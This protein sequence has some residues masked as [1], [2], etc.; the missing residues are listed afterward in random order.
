MLPNIARETISG[1]GDEN[2]IAEYHGLN[3]HLIVPSIPFFQDYPQQAWMSG[4]DWEQQG[5][6][7]ADGYDYNDYYQ[8]PNTH[9]VQS[10]YNG[11]PQ[12]YYGYN[13]EDMV[14]EC[15]I[16]PGGQ[17]PEYHPSR[18]AS[19][20]HEG[21]GQE[22]HDRQSTDELLANHLTQTEAPTSHTN[23]SSSDSRKLEHKSQGAIGQD[24]SGKLAE[25]RAKLMAS[26]SA[27]GGTPASDSRNQEGVDGAKRSPS[28]EDG[29]IMESERP[30]LGRTDSRTDLDELLA[31]GRA[32]AEAGKPPEGDAT[33]REKPA[34]AGS[35]LHD[36][37]DQTRVIFTAHRAES[38]NSENRRPMSKEI[39]KDS[40][41]NNIPATAIKEKQTSGE[42]PKSQSGGPNLSG[43]VEQNHTAQSKNVQAKR[44]PKTQLF[45]AQ[46][47][48]QVR[49]PSTALK[50][51]R[52]QGEQE[53][54]QRL[55]GK[56]KTSAALG[57]SS[58]HQ[59]SKLPAKSDDQEKRPLSPKTKQS[60]YGRE[61]HPS[62]LSK[63][64]DNR[65]PEKQSTAC[66]PSRSDPT[67]EHCMERVKGHFN[68]RAE[69]H[70]SPAVAQ[71][72]ILQ[73]DEERKGAA[74]RHELEEWLEM[75]GY[76]DVDYRR[77]ALR[78]HRDLIALDRARLK[79]ERE[80]QIEQEERSHLARAQSMMPINGIEN[81]SRMTMP[82]VS[83]RAS[84]LIS[85]PPPP[86]PARR[87]YESGDTA[88]S[89]T[90]TS[91][92]PVTPQH[93]QNAIQETSEPIE[94]GALKRKYSERKDG[95]P[96][97][98]PAEKYARTDKDGDVRYHEDARQLTAA[99][100]S[101][102]E[103]YQRSFTKRLEARAASRDTSWHEHSQKR[104]G[105]STSPEQ[106]R[107]SND[108]PS[109]RSRIQY[110]RDTPSPRQS[111]RDR[112]RDIAYF[113]D[114]VE[115][116]EFSRGRSPEVAY[117]GGYKKRASYGHN[118]PVNSTRG[119]GRGR[120]RGGYYHSRG[121]SRIGEQELSKFDRRGSDPLLLRDGGTRYFLVKS[122]NFENVEVAQRE[123]IWATQAKNTELFR[124]AFLTCRH[125]I[126]VFSVNKSTAFQGYARM[127]T[128]PG[129]A[130]KPSWQSSLH[131]Q[132]SPPFRIR[133]IT[134]E[135]THFSLAGRLKNSFNEHQPVLV[136]RDGQEI[137]ANCGA[138]LCELIDEEHATR[139][140][141]WQ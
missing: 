88:L 10:F 103:D 79:L 122:W 82:S 65:T 89:D 73:H 53:P 40:K 69:L 121:G 17:Q 54:S 12:D 9:S 117:R 46:G 84:S 116:G 119:R 4:M 132:A 92:Y 100:K 13:E 93:D 126:L 31:E 109:A 50:I 114:D 128:E 5:D 33:K 19:R 8:G 63:P 16:E 37:L 49:D 30:Q 98:S 131:W 107:L 77:K 64:R 83:T 41:Q 127:E 55:Q 21:S 56:E 118:Y 71:A 95:S 86:V 52:P 136:G 32:A 60:R 101:G 108:L 66:L 141:G 102:P 120:G 24:V 134:V 111:S 47:I 38:V 67:K 59:T 105:K 36:G 57:L 123:E 62:E 124:E 39:R 75:T 99:S 7:T 74:Q 51:P 138:S 3:Q 137:E 70:S 133:W 130:E 110:D 97:R 27:N 72:L 35:K 68:D 104:P 22:R 140:T 18:D 20:H 28:A 106:G 42:N 96:I 43:P 48:D 125:V 112:P 94:N 129:E 76:N 25:L 113:D 34:D 87:E 45:T 61:L 115:G 90:P 81:T 6:Q 14:E 1:Q 11:V 91:S 78:R 58:S 85:M 80:A 135:E 15:E 139:K 2:N 23:S 44:N 29:E 26:R